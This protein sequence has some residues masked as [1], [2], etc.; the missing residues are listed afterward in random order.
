[1]KYILLAT[2]LL[3]FACGNEKTVQLPEIEHSE[4]TEIH[5]VSAAYL[6][7]DE[8]QK[9]SVEFNRKN[10]IGTTNWLVNVD[11]RLTLKQAIPHIKYLQDKRRNA[12]MHKNENAKNYFTCNDTNRKNLGFIEFTD[13][14]F[15]LVEKKQNTTTPLEH[16]VSAKFINFNGNGDIQIVNPNK[17]PLINPSSKNQLIQDLKKAFATN[18]TVNLRFSNKLT[19]QDYI[20]IKAILLNTNSKDFKI[21]NYEFVHL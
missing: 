3:I 18:D 2:S 15:Q 16:E 9:D 8:T 13:V 5:D 4:I 19:F 21:S 20:S 12:Q 14:I 7:Y 11:K 1:M 10:L 6:F 17:K